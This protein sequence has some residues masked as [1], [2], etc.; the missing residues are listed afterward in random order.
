[1]RF[2]AASLII[3]VVSCGTP[4]MAEEISH[5]QIMSG[6]RPPLIPENWIGMPTTSAKGFRWDDPNNPGN[7]V[8]FFD[9]VPHDPN[10]SHRESFVIVISDGKVLNADGNVVT[11]EAAIAEAL[12][13]T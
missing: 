9:G 11:D 8:R 3:L 2:L 13:H 1:M 10:P 4:L 12:Q 7:S 6:K 5:A